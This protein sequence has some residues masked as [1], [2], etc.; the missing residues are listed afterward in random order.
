MKQLN[1]YQVKKVERYLK[2]IQ[3]ENKQIYTDFTDH[4][5]CII[6]DYMELGE[7][8]DKSLKFAMNQLPGS[9]IKSI[10]IFT[11]KLLNMETTFSTRTA[12]LATIPFCL[13]G[14][15][16]MFFNSSFGAPL[17]LLWFSLIASMIFMLGLLCIGWVKNFPRW[18]LPALGFCPLVSLFFMMISIPGVSNGKLGFWALIPLAVT[19][20]IAFLFKP[21]IEPLTKLLVKI[22]EEPTL[23]L[24]ALYGFLPFLLF[25]M[26]DEIHST[27]IGI[28]AII[29]T[30]ILSAGLFFFLRTNTII[31]RIC[32]IVLSSVLTFG[33]VWFF[34]I[35]VV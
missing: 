10:E 32:S 24:F 18:S 7:N 23:I 29:S 33:L 16:W 25:I 27:Q 5:C 2:D 13:F 6:E 15:T 9:T 11:L 4:L 35:E 3:I 28:I 14:L 26:C 8:F 21:S 19:I 1:E 17:P 20:V 34:V 22:K 31:K 12:L 30:L